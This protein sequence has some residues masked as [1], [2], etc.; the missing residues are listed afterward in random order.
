[1]I[2][3]IASTQEVSENV[4]SVQPLHKFPLVKQH[5][6]SWNPEKVDAE[7]L[8]SADF[9]CHQRLLCE[10]QSE[11]FD[12]EGQLSPQGAENMLE[13]VKKSVQA[14]LVAL[15]ET[16][17]KDCD[18]EVFVTL[19]PHDRIKFTNFGGALFASALMLIFL[20]SNNKSNRHPGL[21]MGLLRQGVTM[22]DQVTEKKKRN[23]KKTGWRG[24]K[25]LKM[26]VDFGGVLWEII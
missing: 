4:T 3:E 17:V 12:E 5:W 14:I 21:V 23:K 18:H 13:Q 22:E 6:E 8:W 9:N 2:V 1:M 15:K 20:G 16:K 25:E 10:S 11:L 24:T 19:H 26:I 7:N